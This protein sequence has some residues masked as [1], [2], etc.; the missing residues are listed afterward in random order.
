LVYISLAY[1]LGLYSETRVP[2]IFLLRR[3]L[4]GLRTL[5][6][7][8][9]ELNWEVAGLPELNWVLNWETPVLPER[10]LV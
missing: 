8:L 9:T 10:S 4:R 3:E 1:T 5:V 6:K 7:E 2:V